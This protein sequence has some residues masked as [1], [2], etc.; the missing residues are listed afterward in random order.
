[1][2]DRKE[3]LDGPSGMSGWG[4][5][6]I[7]TN[8][9]QFSNNH[10]SDGHHLEDGLQIIRTGL[11]QIHVYTKLF[12]DREVLK[13]EKHPPTISDKC[14]QSGKNNTDENIGFFPALDMEDHG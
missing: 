11:R 6:S 2:T 7:P 3:A 1:M 10:L 9:P 8:L 14:S 13:R 12:G 5:S 4:S